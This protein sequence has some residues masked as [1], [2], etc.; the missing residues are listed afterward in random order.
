MHIQDCNYDIIKTSVAYG[1][2]SLNLKDLFIYLISCFT[3]IYFLNLISCI[4]NS[5][6]I[7]LFLAALC[8]MQGLTSLTRD[9][10]HTP[11]AVEARSLNHRTARELPIS[12]YFLRDTR[13]KKKKLEIE[14]SDGQ[15][16]VF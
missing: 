6:F 12:M 10:I 4:C 1:F 9:G 15:I 5:F 13:I 14:K 7:L 3:S 11:P 2:L 16:R 8:S